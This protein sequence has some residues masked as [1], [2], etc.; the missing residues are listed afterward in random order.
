MH[1]ITIKEFQNNIYKELLA[2]TPDANIETEAILEHIT[3]LKD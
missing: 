2:L 1:K 3:K